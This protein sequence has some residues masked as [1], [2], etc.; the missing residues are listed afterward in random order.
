[1]VL[2]LLESEMSPE[3]QRAFEVFMR[4]WEITDIH[5]GN[6]SNIYNGH[7]KIVDYAGWGW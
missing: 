7:R 6:V 2:D 5:S 4:K 1:M 3:Y